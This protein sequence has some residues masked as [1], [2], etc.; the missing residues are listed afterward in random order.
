LISLLLLSTVLP[1]VLFIGLF[2]AFIPYFTRPELIFGIRF[3]DHEN[4]DPIINGLKKRNIIYDI[5]ISLVFIVLAVILSIYISALIASLFPIL[6]LVPLTLVYFHFRGITKHMKDEAGEE[7]QRNSTVSAYIPKSGPNV[8]ALW[9]ALPWIELVIFIVIGILYYPSIP[10]RFA[11]HFGLNGK[12]DEYSTKSIFSVFSLLVFTAIPLTVLLEVISYAIQRTRPGSN[13]A[14]P[15]KSSIQMKG[16]NARIVKLLVG[17]NMIILVTLFLSSLIV[18][19]VISSSYTFIVPLPVIVILP[20]VFWFAASSG[21][22]GWKMYQ[23]LNDTGGKDNTLDDDRE[24]AGGLVYHNKN[25]SKILVPK[26]YGV[27]YTFNF[28]NKWSWVILIV[29]VGIPLI[30]IVLLI[31]FR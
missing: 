18:W 26:R 29:I 31:L 20:L 22:T 2:F 17:I 30:L 11:T 4:Y 19:N 28:S 9:Y 24:W 13:N 7:N 10:D 25:D 27:G 1:V 12:P 16:F 8:N 14:Q 23:N 21:Q 3:M 6:E 5:S 15:M